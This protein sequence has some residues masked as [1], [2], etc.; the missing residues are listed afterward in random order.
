MLARLLRGLRDVVWREASASLPR[1]GRS[2]DPSADLGDVL[3][4]QP[5]SG[6]AQVRSLMGRHYLQHLRAF[7]GEDLDAAGFWGKLAQL[8]GAVA[9]ATEPRP[10]AAACADGLR[11]PGTRAHGAAGAGGRVSPTAPLTPNYV[12][13]LLDVT[14]LDALAALPAGTPAVPLLQALVRH[15]LLRETANAG[16]QLLARGGPLAATALGA[17]RRARRPRAGAA[18]HTD[19]AVAT[20]AERARRGPRPHGT[21][22]P[23]C[24]ARG[25]GFRRRGIAPSRRASRQ[26]CTNCTGRQRVACASCERHAR[27]H[28]APA[29]RVDHV[30]RNAAAGARAHRAAGRPAHRRLRLGREPETGGCAYPGRAAGWRIGAARS[31][32]RPTRGS[33]MRRR[34]TRP[35][36][37]RSCATV[38]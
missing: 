37:R 9:G 17:R 13:Q 20:G 15:A 34:S 6:G 21:R 10:H 35:P 31:G 36:R 19:V 29:R 25:P 12:Q 8:G 1:V 30:A 33:S 3:R 5:L 14:D 24:G 2:D 18:T 16:A 11:C 28:V 23:G 4:M 32:G 26:P 7:L 38:T 22:V 27:P